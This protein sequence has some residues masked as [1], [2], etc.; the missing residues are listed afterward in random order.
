MPAMTQPHADPEPI[1]VLARA[2][3]E[4]LRQRI[5]GCPAWDDLDMTDLF[6]SGLIRLAYQRAKAVVRMGQSD[7]RAPVTSA[8]LERG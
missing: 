3:H 6:E 5:Q 4:H 8:A 1:D 2:M 7:P